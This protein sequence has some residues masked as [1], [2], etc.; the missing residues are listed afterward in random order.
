MADSFKTD[1]FG[2]KIFTYRGKTIEELKDMSMD[3]FMG[4]VKSRTRRHFKRGFSDAE[5]KLMSEI[6]NNPDKFVKTHLRDM[7]VLP[8]FVGKTIGI[9]SGK[10]FVS[11]LIQ[12]EMLGH[13]L[14]EFS[15]TRKSVKHSGVGAGA[16]RSTKF[17]PLK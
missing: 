14:G 6:K 11:V 8:D 16:T 2:K 3:E 7:I 1:Q 4:F 15:P 17:V 13:R 12:N 9:Y 5:K 10:G